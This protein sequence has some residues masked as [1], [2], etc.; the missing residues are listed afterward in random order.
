M[1]IYKCWQRSSRFR[2]KFVCVTCISSSTTHP[3]TIIGSTQDLVG[4]CKAVYQKA[5][6]LHELHIEFDPYIYAI[7]RVDS[8]KPLVIIDGLCAA[9]K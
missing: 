6:T 4:F 3:H 7:A 8:N 2:N 9:S 1:V 5:E